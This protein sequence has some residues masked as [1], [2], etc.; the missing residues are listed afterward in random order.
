MFEQTLRRFLAL[1]EA[2]TALRAFAAER[3]LSVHYI[4]SDSNLDFH[5]V[6]GD[7]AV[8]AG[9]GPPPGRPDLTLTG[10]ASTFEGIMTGALNAMAAA[11]LGQLKYRGDTVKAVALQRVSEDLTRLYLVAQAA[12][13]G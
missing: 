10:N 13:E 8:Q 6:F 2:D 7:G 11:M 9:L 12:P 1:C 4:I 5:M 3:R